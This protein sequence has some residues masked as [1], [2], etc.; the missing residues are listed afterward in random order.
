M[1]LTCHN[2]TMFVVTPGIPHL[3]IVRSSGSNTD[4]PP[5][6]HT[7]EFEGSPASAPGLFLSIR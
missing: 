1:N 2:C 7:A 6:A 4:E 5:R 3:N